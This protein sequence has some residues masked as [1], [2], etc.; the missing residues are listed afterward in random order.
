MAVRQAIYESDLI[1]VDEGHGWT[2]V[3]G[4]PDSIRTT[5]KDASEWT[6]R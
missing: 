3:E 4:L 2:I 1:E 5:V 6:V